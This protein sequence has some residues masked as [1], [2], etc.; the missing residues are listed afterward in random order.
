[1]GLNKSF[2]LGILVGIGL[3]SCAA[4]SFNYKYYVLNMVKYDG[5]LLGPTPADDK[6]LATCQGNNCVCMYKSDYLAL[7]SDYKEISQNLVD[8]QKGN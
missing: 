1:M 6:D 7:K 2:I 8:C 4:I 5:K 3:T